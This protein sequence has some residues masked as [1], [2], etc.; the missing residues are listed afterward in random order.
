MKGL[1]R[2]YDN[3]AEEN[4]VSIARN[5]KTSGHSNQIFDKMSPKIMIKSVF[6]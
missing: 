6:K 1:R 2:V 3:N 4:L 5:T